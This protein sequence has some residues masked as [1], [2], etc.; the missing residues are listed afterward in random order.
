MN[1]NIKGYKK[2]KRIR[3]INR[4]GVYHIMIGGLHYCQIFSPENERLMGYSG[5]NK[6]S[7]YAKAIEYAENLTE[8]S[9]RSTSSPYVEEGV[10]IN[11]CLTY[12]NL[13][14]LLSIVPD[15]GRFNILRGKL[16]NG[17]RKSHEGREFRLYKRQPRS[18]TDIQSG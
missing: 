4:C 11:V 5:A 16:L 3:T 17:L 1:I 15:N 13:V 10:A 18:R 7:C 14:D 12:N 8:Y 9:S 2:G 6:Q